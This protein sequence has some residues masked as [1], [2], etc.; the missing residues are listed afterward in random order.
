MCNLSARPAD[1]AARYLSVVL[2]LAAF[3][4]L[5]PAVAADA[6]A[7][8][9]V[10]EAIVAIEAQI[11]ADARTADTLGKERGGSGV[12]IDSEG[13]VLTIGYL[14]L[15]AE[16]V[17][18]RTGSGRR[19][20]ASVIAYHGDTGFG[21]LRA[22]GDL[23]VRPMR[24]GSAD[25]LKSR[26]R[27]LVAAFGGMKGVLP[28]IVTERRLFAGAWEYLL[29]DAIF[30][31]PP[32]PLA[33]GAA[34]IG[35]DGH[36]LGIGYLTLGSVLSSDVQV[37]GNMFVPVDALKPVMADLVADGRGPGAARPWLGL[38][39]EEAKG[40]VFVERVA[41]GGPADK[42]GIRAG[43]IV[44]KVGD[45]PVAGMADL[46]RKVWAIGDAGVAVPLTILQ[47]ADLQDVRVASGD[48][49]RW[50]RHARSF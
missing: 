26:D 45:E 13:L 5:R 41:E 19:V 29:D 12:V 8:P 1:D 33:A 38:Y 3:L 34:L 2:V 28:A 47:E 4:G 46:Y 32:H 11:P 22:S 10:L 27:V 31:A 20:P 40:R 30:T 14:V 44:L 18:V 7:E 43:D 50:F 21:L 17:I 35:P 37:P 48:R 23:E 42:A 15:E 16:S 9:E 24:L 49:H 25:R 6:A 39:T 36:L